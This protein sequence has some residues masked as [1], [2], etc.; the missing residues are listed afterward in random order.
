MGVTNYL[1]TGIIL[2][3][4]LMGERV[5]TFRVSDAKETRPKNAFSEIAW[6]DFPRRNVYIE[7]RF[8]PS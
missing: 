8:W 4:W 7:A 3:A 2:Q 6:T 1:Q 5:K